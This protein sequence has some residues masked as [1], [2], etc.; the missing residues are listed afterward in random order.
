MRGTVAKRIA[1]K[2]RELATIRK[3]PSI[4]KRIVHRINGPRPD[5]ARFSGYR[6]IYQDLKRVYRSGGTA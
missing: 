6:R 1:K 5:Q 4:L 3:T 2:A